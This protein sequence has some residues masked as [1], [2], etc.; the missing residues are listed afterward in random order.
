MLSAFFG[1]L[2]L[3]LAAVGLSGVVAH[4]A[5]ARQTEIGLRTGLRRRPFDEPPHS[6]SAVVGLSPKARRVG[7][8]EATA[9]TDSMQT[10]APTKV[11]GSV[12]VTPQS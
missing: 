6:R 10:S 4:A 12:G 9:A 7:S 3:L 2:A 1:G 5:R 11:S 8:Q